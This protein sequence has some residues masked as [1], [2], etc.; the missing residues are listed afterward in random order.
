[1]SIKNNVVLVGVGALVLGLVLGYCV[2]VRPYN[3]SYGMM[4]NWDYS[5]EHSDG[6]SSTDMYDAMGSMMG[7]LEGKTGDALDKAFIDGMIVHHEGAVHMAQALVAGTKRPELLKLGND[8]ITAQ[9]K[10]IETMRT[11][12]TE[13]FTK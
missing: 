9:T 11:W 6:Y 2:G 7:G 10:E 3:K 8:I 1:M 5:G 12:R 13:W 4:D